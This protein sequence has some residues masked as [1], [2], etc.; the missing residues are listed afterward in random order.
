MQ[1]CDIDKIQIEIDK[2][3]VKTIM[4]TY[5]ILNNKYKEL[6]DIKEE[7]ESICF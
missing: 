4:S 5:Q 7:S 6:R 2:I 3:I 1:G